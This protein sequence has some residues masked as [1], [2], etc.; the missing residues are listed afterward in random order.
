MMGSWGRRD[1]HHFYFC[2]FFSYDFLVLRFHVSERNISLHPNVYNS[3]E[4]SSK[5]INFW[6]FFSQL[7]PYSENEDSIQSHCTESTKQQILSHVFWINFATQILRSPLVPL[8]LMLSL[9]II[10]L[11]LL[12]L[13][14][15]I[16]IIAIIMNN[17]YL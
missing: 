8:P 3:M 6:N 14:P 4:N 13:V 11:L 15:L 16:I 2:S 9:L 10:I 17:C 7:Y 12:L 5:V 1:F